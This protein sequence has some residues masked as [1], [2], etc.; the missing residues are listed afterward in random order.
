LGV[1]SFILVL[2]E[3]MAKITQK[4]VEC[5]KEFQTYHE[6]FKMYC[7]V[8]CKMRKYEEH[9]PECGWH[10]DWHSC[11]CGAFDLKEVEDGTNST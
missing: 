2:R 4:C 7:S 9:P 6:E 3:L 1:R 11:S 8:G 10:R 5:Q